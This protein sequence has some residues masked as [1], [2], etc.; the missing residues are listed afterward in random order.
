MKIAAW[1][2]IDRRRIVM[3]WG[4]M[5]AL[6]HLNNT[7]YFRYL[8]Q[9][10]ID[11]LE[12]LGEA[13]RPGAAGPVIASTGCTFL[14]ELRYPGELD[15]TIE[16]EHLG[17]SSLKLRHRFFRY[18]SGDDIVYATAEAVLVWVDYAQGQATALPAVL[19]AAVEGALAAAGPSVPE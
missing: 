1:P 18:G 3:R 19:R 15:I 7:C 14:R 10:R 9:I 8:E 12:S 13:I 4:D 5:D 2:I 6:G 11:W 17:R 16:I